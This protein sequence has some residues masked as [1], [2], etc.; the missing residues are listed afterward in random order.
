MAAD[1]LK[2]AADS[3]QHVEMKSAF[4]DPLHF[5]FC[6]GKSL[7]LVKSEKTMSPEAIDATRGLQS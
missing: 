7:K 2:M 4:V 5:T 3:S 6:E 1:L